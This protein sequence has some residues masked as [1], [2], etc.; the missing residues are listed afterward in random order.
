MPP[1]HRAFGE[2]IQQQVAQVDPVDLGPGERGVVRGVLLEEQ[3]AVG[4]EEAQVLA[5]GPGDRVELVDQAGFAQRPL[6]GMDVEHAALAAR[7]AGR[8]PFVDDG[9]DPVDVQHPGESQAAEARSDDRDGHR[10]HSFDTPYLSIQ[11][12]D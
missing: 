7:V 4:L 8:L 6:P 12:I 10:C 5:F 1:A 11:C 3:G 2:R 9:V